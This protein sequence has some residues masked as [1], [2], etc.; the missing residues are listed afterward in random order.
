MHLK[1]IMAAIILGFVC[2]F[3]CVL[4]EIIL[5]LAFAEIKSDYPC[6]V[7]EVKVSL[8]VGIIVFKK[9]NKNLLE[10]STNPN[11]FNNNIKKE[12]RYLSTDSYSETTYYFEI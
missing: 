7:E 1:I 10:N 6:E 12:K 5:S 8:G 9:N 2:L 3:L 11:I 4:E